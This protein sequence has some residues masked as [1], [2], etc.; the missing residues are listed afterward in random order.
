V[1]KTLDVVGR[2]GVDYGLGGK[3]MENDG[4]NV[5]A[6]GTAR[7]WGD[8]NSERGGGEGATLKHASPK[9]RADH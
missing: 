9:K 2:R 3:M 5:V 4:N 7:E 6:R 1:G 8:P